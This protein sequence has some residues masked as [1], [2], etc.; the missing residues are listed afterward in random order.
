MW[1]RTGL[2]Q[3]PTAR[4]LKPKPNTLTSLLLKAI[5][6]GLGHFIP[7]FS[8]LFRFLLSGGE[9]IA[10]KGACDLSVCVSL[11]LS[12]CHDLACAPCF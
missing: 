9:R 8:R 12:L 11:S 2:D 4:T 3:N 5:P 7:R 6:V 1:L 10:V